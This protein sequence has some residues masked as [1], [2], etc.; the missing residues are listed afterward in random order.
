MR[1]YRQQ[2]LL[3][4]IELKDSVYRAK[5]HS[6]HQIMDRN[7]EKCPSCNHKNTIDCPRCNVEMKAV[8]YQDLK[9]DAC[10]NCKGVWFDEIELS[11]IW[12]MNLDAI[13]RKKSSGI[14]IDGLE[15]ALAADLFLDVLFW[16][17]HLLHQGGQAAMEAGGHIIGGLGHLASNAPEVA[18]QAI[19]ATGELA[20]S[21]FEIIAKIIGEILSGLD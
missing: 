4:R 2:A 1:Q 15:G 13:S 8:H 20:G 3:S 16:N 7:V 17:P 5:C 11:E 14:A 6:C 10:S 21:V 12:N 19:E 18:G 9:L